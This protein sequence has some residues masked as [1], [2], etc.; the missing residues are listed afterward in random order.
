MTGSFLSLALFKKKR[1]RVLFF[2]QRNYYSFENTLVLITRYL[3]LAKQA[4]VN[5]TMVSEKTVVFS[6]YLENTLLSNRA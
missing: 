1:S 3:V 4:T 2:M 5:K 6:E